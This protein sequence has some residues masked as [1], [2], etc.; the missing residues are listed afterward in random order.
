MAAMTAS[1]QRKLERAIHLLTGAM[2]LA[3]LYL[4]AGRELAEVVRF[5]VFPVLALSGVTMW[6]A[7]RLRPALKAARRRGPVRLPLARPPA[8][9]AR[10]PALAEPT[11]QP[12]RRR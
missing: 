7:P 4:P 9:A 8:V 11:S 5:L 10:E 12:K 6:Q 1:R 2:L 3:Y